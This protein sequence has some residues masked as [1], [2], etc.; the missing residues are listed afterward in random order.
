MRLLVYVVVYINGTIVHIRASIIWQCLQFPTQRH[1]STHCH[2]LARLLIRRWWHLRHFGWRAS[3]LGRILR[4]I[5][6][7]LR[8]LLRR[9]RRLLR[10]LRWLSWPFTHVG[11]WDFVACSWFVS[12]TCKAQKVWEICCSH[13]YVLVYYVTDLW[14]IFCSKRNWLIGFD[15]LIVIYYHWLLFRCY[16]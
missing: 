16:L 8:C 10:R 15:C 9:L 11:F 6:S 5:G 4:H 7:V 13:I 2:L 1:S 14:L 3:R 12:C